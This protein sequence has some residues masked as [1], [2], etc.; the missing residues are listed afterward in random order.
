[1][2]NKQRQ[3]RI[4][5]IQQGPRVEDLSANVADLLNSI[6]EAVRGGVD[7]I[8]ATELS[9]TPYFCFEESGSEYRRW[10][11]ALESEVVGPVA[12]KA[13]EH[14]TT[15]ILPFFRRESSG[16]QFFNSAV[17][18]GPDGNMVSG[19]LRGGNTV[20][21]YAKVH[22]PKVHTE[23]LKIDETQHFERGNGFP[24][25]AT[26]KGADRYPHLLRPP[27]SGGLAY[28]GVERRGD[29]LS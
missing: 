16:Q 25:F 2:R 12:A 23:M 21:C 22:L 10:A 13:R 24:V 4:V 8:V 20:K 19:E 5:S 15:I 7:Y 14:H 26:E 6:D 27:I 17:V 28:V 18:I 29:S 9:L 3:V 1:M 11:Q